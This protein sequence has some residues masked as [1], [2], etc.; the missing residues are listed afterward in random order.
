MVV[1]AI[2]LCLLITT[3]LRKPFWFDEMLTYHVSG[4]ESFSRVLDALRAGVDGMP[5]AYYLAVRL[6]RMLPIS[7][8]I[9]LRLPSI[10]GYFLTL[11][12]VYWFIA[13]RM[14]RMAGF[15]GVLLVAISPF[16]TM[17]VE[18]RS[19]ALLAGVLAVAAA[20]WQRIGERRLFT[21]LLALCLAAGVSL[22]HMAVVTVSGFVLGETLFSVRQR[23]V[24]PGVWVAFGISL[25]PFLLNLPTLLHFKAVLG[26]H[27]WTRPSLGGA[28][29]TYAEY[30]NMD[31]AL[32]FAVMLLFLGSVI[33]RGRSDTPLPVHEA[34]LAA[35]FLVYPMALQMLTKVAG[36]GYTP[37]YGWPVVLGLAVAFVYL[38]Q[39]VRAPFVSIF[40][41]L[42]VGCLAQDVMDIRNAVPRVDFSRLSRLSEAEQSLPVV[43]GSGYE[44]MKIRKYAPAEL[45]PRLI[46]VADPDLAIERIGTD[47][48]DRAN[49]LLMDFVPLPFR[50]FDQLASAYPRFYFASGG[51]FEWLMNYLIAKGY[52]L[53][54]LGPVDGGLTLYMARQ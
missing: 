50:R 27:F 49:A 39:S 20:V 45:R 11:A 13:K 16:R 6:A 44:F 14:G 15:V 47:S 5:P 4:L 18:A 42:V 33:S 10:I 38:L 26:T 1:I 54:L 53:E 35:A 52:H 32:L 41:A 19:Y 9:T 22:H 48:I 17:A 7:E 2:Q 24:R 31:V 8:Q 25:I 3:A 36:G 37:R 23:K 40:A 28:F 30:S 51:G 46:S 43:I 21:P 34:A 12:G 29:S